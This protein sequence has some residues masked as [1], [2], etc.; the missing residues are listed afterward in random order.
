MGD[1]SCT[2]RTKKFLT[3]RLLQQTNAHSQANGVHKALSVQK[4]KRSARDLPKA[5]VLDIEGTVAPISFVSD[6]LFPYAKSHLRSHLVNTYESQETQEDIESLRKQARGDDEEGLDVIMIPVE[7]V[8][9]DIID[10]CVA[11][12]YKQMESDRKTT[13]LKQLQGHIWRA[14]YQQGELKADLFPE[15]SDILGEWRDLGIKTYIYS[16]GSREAQRLLFANTKVGDLRPYLY[17]FFDTT[18]GSKVETDS[19]KNIALCIGMDLSQD[20]LFVTDRIGEAKAAYQAGW[21]VQLA[22]REGNPPLESDQGFQVV[23]SMKEVL[24]SC[25]QQTIVT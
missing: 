10:A 1:K 23:Y 5:I 25:S 20:I 3:N 24:E 7:G 9:D 22:V 12:V 11:N 21:K 15:V 13:A 17:G 8:K 16:S 18:F 14:G 2:V 4:K 19:Y 6:V